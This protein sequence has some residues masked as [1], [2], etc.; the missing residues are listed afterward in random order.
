MD[1]YLEQEI[2]DELELMKNKIESFLKDCNIEVTSKTF[3]SMLKKLDEV[4]AVRK[5]KSYIGVTLNDRGYVTT[6]NSIDTIID[7]Q[8]LPMD[9]LRGYYKIE[10]GK[11]VVD[12]LM[13]DK[14][15]R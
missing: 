1:S 8:E 9:I 3:W 7:E 4:I 5:D 13:K 11:L 14:L 15:W 10:N 6:I 2:S 12:E